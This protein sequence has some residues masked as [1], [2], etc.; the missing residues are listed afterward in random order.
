MTKLHKFNKA[1]F[2]DVAMKGHWPKDLNEY[3]KQRVCH[4][5][6]QE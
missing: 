4:Q 3:V 2:K 1:L 5:P 6:Q